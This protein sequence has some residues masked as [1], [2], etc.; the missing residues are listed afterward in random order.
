MLKNLDHLE[1]IDNNRHTMKIRDDNSTVK[2]IA[3]KKQITSKIKHIDIVYHFTREEIADK[4]LS[5]TQ[6]LTANMLAD[7]LIKS[8]DARQFEN[9]RER[10]DMS[11]YSS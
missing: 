8:L 10:I 3:K 5:I 4:R 6:V 2:I 1:L 7:E 9:H 11:S